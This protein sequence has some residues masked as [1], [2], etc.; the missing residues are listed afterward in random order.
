MA[1]AH[2]CRS[3]HADRQRQRQREKVAGENKCTVLWRASALFR[4]RVGRDE[5]WIDTGSSGD[6][7]LEE[8][9]TA[10]TCASCAVAAAAEGRRALG[11]HLSEGAE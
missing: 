3:T 7:S 4:V 11:L 10:L 9:Q 5:V 1:K 8:A 2:T 6:P